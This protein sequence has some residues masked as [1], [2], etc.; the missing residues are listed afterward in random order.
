MGIRQTTQVSLIVS[1]GDLI[2]IHPKPY[3][4]YLRGGGAIN[5][6]KDEAMGHSRGVP[7]M[8]IFWV[9]AKGLQLGYQNMGI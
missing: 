4:I 2:I 1:Y 9:A 7:M 6:K 5:P 8:R 3:S